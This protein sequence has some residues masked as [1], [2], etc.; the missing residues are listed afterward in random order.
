MAQINCQ[1]YNSKCLVR[2]N[3]SFGI[4]AS[5]KS[6]LVGKLEKNE[7]NYK[8]SLSL[9]RKIMHFLFDKNAKLYILK[10]GK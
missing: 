1:Q 3:F 7:K 6:S 5:K 2:T 9:A 8:A 10:P 4:Q